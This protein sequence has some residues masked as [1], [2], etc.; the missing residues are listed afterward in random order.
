MHLDGRINTSGYAS[1]PV[2]EVNPENDAIDFSSFF[3]EIQIER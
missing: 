2:I 3:R 1:S